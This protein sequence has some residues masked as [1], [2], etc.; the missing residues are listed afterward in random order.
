MF[1]GYFNNYLL[2]VQRVGIYYSL[3]GIT[4]LNYYIC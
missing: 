4:F 2:I 3:Q 1:I